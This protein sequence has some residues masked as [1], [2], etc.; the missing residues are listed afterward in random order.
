MHIEG[1]EL[2][3]VERQFITSNNI[4]DYEV[5]QIESSSV[6]TGVEDVTLTPPPQVSDEYDIQSSEDEIDNVA[7]FDTVAR[8]T[9][10]INDNLYRNS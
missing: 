7:E 3:E 5:D 4:E 10:A 9:S 1:D 6:P 2:P 8:T